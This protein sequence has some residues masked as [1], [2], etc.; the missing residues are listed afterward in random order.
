MFTG[1]FTGRCGMGTA[2]IDRL[3][4]SKTARSLGWAV[5]LYAASVAVVASVAYVLRALIL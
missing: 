1:S 4:R 5:F 3:R 2:I